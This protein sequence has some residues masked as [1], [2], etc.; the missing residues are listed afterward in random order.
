M[1]G[2]TF[3][4]S[5]SAAA[6]AGSLLLL[7]STALAETY[8]VGEGMAYGA[9]GEV[10]W[11]ALMPGDV[12]R[13]HWRAEPYREKFVIARQGTEAAPIVVQGV[14]GPGGERPVI[15]GEDATTRSA[16]SY[17]GESRGVIKIGG[18]SVPEETIPA[19]IVVENLEVRSAR[20]PFSFTGRG[21]A[22]TYSNNAAA[23]YVE[24]AQNLTIRNCVMRDSGNGL[25]IGARG[26]DTQDILIEGNHI[27][28]NGIEGRIFE[29]NAYT[30]AIGITYQFNHF[31]PLRDGARG[32]NLKD[33]SAGL[34]VR[35]NWIESGNRQLDLVDAEDSRVLVDHPSYGRTF[36]YGNVLVEHEGDGNSQI[37]HYGGDSGTEGDYRKGVLHFFHNT[38]VSTRSGNTTLLRLSTNDET[39][40]VRNNLLYVTAGGGRL[41][42]LDGAGQLSLHHNWMR[43]GRV[44]SHGALEGSI[45]DDGTTVTG[46]DP[47]FADEAGQDYRLAEGAGAIDAAGA[48][49]ADAMAAHS[50]LM[51]YVVHQ[52]SEGRP[53]AGAADIGAF[54]HCAPGACEAPPADAGVMADGGVIPGSDG[55]PSGGRDG[56][57][58]AGPDGGS[59]EPAPDGG[60]GC[61]APGTAA[62]DAALPL[63][64]LFALWLRLRRRAR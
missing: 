9:I 17:W 5:W 38:V 19:W 62:P 57:A 34:V 48:L 4:R 22:D 6:L 26:G 21:G 14:L 45:S 61:S 63:L 31:G 7:S 1:G 18:S 56:G 44:D 50:V 42:M 8:E 13:I 64:G 59:A 23:I 49:A 24:V 46:E 36:V 12:V 28:D 27:Y 53:S 40:D 43:P 3:A 25:F 10:P 60:C 39:A 37:V 30:A 20:P 58:T 55:G 11:E 15:S 35:Y 51:Q 54:E 47:A 2:M 52:L 29:H 41:A 32:N 33:R 16:L